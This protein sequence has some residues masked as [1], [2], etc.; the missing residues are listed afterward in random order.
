MKEHE[1]KL[2]IL[3][4]MIFLYITE[5]Y[6]NDKFLLSL[7]EQYNELEKTLIPIYD[8]VERTKKVMDKMMKG[9][10]PSEESNYFQVKNKKFAEELLKDFANDSEKYLEE[11]DF[12]EMLKNTP[13]EDISEMFL[14]KTPEETKKE[15][16]DE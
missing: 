1:K 2:D 16:S 12:R 9:V 4:K 14:N 11:D 15:Q 13:K 5:T 3:R 10:K 6:S 7:I 8:I